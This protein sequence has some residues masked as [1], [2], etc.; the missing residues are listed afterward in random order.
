[1][2]RTAKKKDVEILTDISFESKG[3]WQYPK[4]YFDIWKDELTITIEY[5]KK[6]RV[7]VIEQKGRIVGYY[8]LVELKEDLTISDITLNKGFWLDHMFLLPQFIGKGLGAKIF[9]HLVEQCKKLQI[10]SFSVLA[11]PNSK[12]FYEKMG[13]KYQKEYP[14]TIK[15]RTTPLL[16]YSLFSC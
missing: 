16:K 4:H 5:I 8:S 9:K 2:I 11:D 1:M 6:N 10:S 12:R 13:C 15:N 14:S 7:F 3:Y